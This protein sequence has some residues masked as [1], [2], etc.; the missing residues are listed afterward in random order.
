MYSLF[1]TLAR[2]LEDER[3]KRPLEA[4]SSDYYHAGKRLEELQEELRRLLPAE[5]QKIVNRLDEECFA[6][7]AAG[8]GVSYRQGLADGMR[9][10]LEAL[11]WS[12]ARG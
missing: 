1:E 2:A 8:A 12:P 6:L 4:V 5:E 11:V 3:S 10:I 7:V 9:L